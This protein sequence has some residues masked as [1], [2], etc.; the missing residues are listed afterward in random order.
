MQR[1]VCLDMMTS[2]K[3]HPAADSQEDS[4]GKACT[5]PLLEDG[6]LWGSSRAALTRIGGLI[7]N[8]LVGAR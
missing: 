4:A 2:M 6:R 1:V 5:Q 3:G 8:T 7:P